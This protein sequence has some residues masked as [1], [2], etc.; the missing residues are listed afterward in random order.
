MFLLNKDQVDLIKNNKICLIKK[1]TLIEDVY[2]FDFISALLEENDLHVSQK[3]SIGN[4]KDVFQI[5]KVSNTQRK[6]KDIF[7]FLY[8][9]FKYEKNQKD[10][11]DLFFSLVSQVGNPHIDEEDVFI[12]GLQ[13]VTI[14]RV[15]NTEYTDYQIEKGDMIFIPKGIKHKVIGL[16]PRIIAS[17]G[18]YGNKST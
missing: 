4:L 1:F 6:F 14:Y 9:I 15:F 17:I 13:G 7:Y 18:F 2:N 16:T 11:V 3:T 8:K 5:F 10:E 12:V